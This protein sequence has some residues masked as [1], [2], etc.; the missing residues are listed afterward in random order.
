MN[1][2]D[3]NGKS[4]RSPGSKLDTGKNRVGLVLGT[5]ANAL[6]A[7]S[8]VGTFGANKYT[9]NG[10]LTVPNGRARYTDAMLRHYLKESMGEALDQDSKLHHAAHLAWNAL[11]RLELMLRE[12][13]V[14]FSPVAEE[15]VIDWKH[16]FADWGSPTPN[17]CWESHVKSGR[18]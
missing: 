4:P 2:I 1:D 6:V 5:F 12:G 16:R 15:A 9:D 3:P 14:E 11:A 8:A 10:W 18:G 17:E 13:E 7:V